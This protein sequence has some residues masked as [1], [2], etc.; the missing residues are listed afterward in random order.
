MRLLKRWRLEQ[1]EVM[2]VQEFEDEYQ[3]YETRYSVDYVRNHSARLTVLSIATYRLTWSVAHDHYYGLRDLL[4]A[5]RFIQQ[6]SEA[7]ETNLII[8]D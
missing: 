1:G 6:E 8:E 5:L 4:R 7:G 3:F 2:K